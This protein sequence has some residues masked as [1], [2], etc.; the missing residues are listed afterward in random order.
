MTDRPKRITE[1][2][3]AELWRRAA[4]LQAHA[5][6]RGQALAPV[7]DDEEGLSL[8]QVSAAAESAGIA[9]DYVRLALA[10]RRLPDAGELRATSWS[11]RS[12]RFLL[13]R[14]GAIEVSR[15]L[16][17]PPERV[18]DAVRTVFP[19][20]PFELLSEDTVGG[21]PLRDGVLVYRLGSTTSSEFHSSL[22]WADARVVLATI[23]AEGE[24]TRLTLRAP[25]FR[26]GINVAATSAFSALGA[27]GGAAVGGGI[28]T[29]LAAAPAL[30]LLPVLAGVAAG[31]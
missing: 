20:A 22:N 4:E 26:R 21:D 30:V 19:A 23:R 12:A 29:L 18:F 7:D 17:V 15:V 9:P 5:E 10:E 2:E 31:G 1:A 14:V 6:S 25:L 24:G 8:E 13:D 3:A 28:A 16:P 27:W 11:V